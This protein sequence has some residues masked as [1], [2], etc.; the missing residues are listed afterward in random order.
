MVSALQL[1]TGQR[2]FAGYKTQSSVGE[3]ASA[4]WSSSSDTTI[5]AACTALTAE[6]DDGS[7]PTNGAFPYKDWLGLSTGEPR[8]LGGLP[9]MLEERQIG[10]GPRNTII[11]MN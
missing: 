3:L 11:A 10:F 2:S 5:S 1:I 6:A 7:D 4:R 8:F 9:Y